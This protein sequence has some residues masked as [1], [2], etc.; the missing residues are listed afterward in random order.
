MATSLSLDEQR[1]ICKLYES[2]KSF[3]EIREITGRSREAQIRVL[4]SVGLYKDG[5]LSSANEQARHNYEV[6]KDKGAPY[7]H[8]LELFERE[9]Y[10]NAEID[11]IKKNAKTRYNLL[12]NISETDTSENEPNINYIKVQDILDYCEKVKT[13]VVEL[14]QKNLEVMKTTDVYKKI[15]D[16]ASADIHLQ[17]LYCTYAYDIPNMIK[18]IQNGKAN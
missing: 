2:G 8:K 7:W 6:H 10:I 17:Q 1:T 11:K 4:T 13:T 18:E 3:K 5:L 14:R 16:C 15:A 9:R 12:F